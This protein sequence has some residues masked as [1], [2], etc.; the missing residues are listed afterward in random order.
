MGQTHL[1]HK[2]SQQNSEDALMKEMAS[3]VHAG[4]RYEK[5]RAVVDE[6]Q[7]H[8]GEPSVLPVMRL[9]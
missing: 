7:R 2:D 5:Q 9:S 1:A 6:A 3:E 8:S 4:N